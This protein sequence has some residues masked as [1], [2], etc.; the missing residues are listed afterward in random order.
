M[1][2]PIQMLSDDRPVEAETAAGGVDHTIMTLRGAGVVTD[3]RRVGRIAVGLCLVGLAVL[4]VVLFV[5]GVDKNAQIT[6][7][8]RDGV[9]VTVTSTGCT[10]P[11]GRERQQPG[12]LRLP[13]DLH[14]RRSPLQRAPPG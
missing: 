1:N 10:G 12:R 7:L 14:R 2:P 5:A 11:L 3:V 4:V 13:G 9:P 6:R 8:H